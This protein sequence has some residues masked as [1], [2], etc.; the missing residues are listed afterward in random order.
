M[1]TWDDLNNMEP[2]K[3]YDKGVTQE[4]YYSSYGE[5]NVLL[6][7]YVRDNIFTMRTMRSR[8]YIL[9]EIPKSLEATSARSNH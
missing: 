8:E 5:F 9:F 2:I 4:P 1:L 7:D 6:R 3:V